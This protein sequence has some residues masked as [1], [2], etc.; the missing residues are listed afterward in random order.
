LIHQATAQSKITAVLDW[1][2]TPSLMSN[3]IDAPKIFKVLQ[4]KMA[5]PRLS[6]CDSTIHRQD[7]L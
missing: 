2:L 7:I 3:T 6:S 5:F 1:V 4:K